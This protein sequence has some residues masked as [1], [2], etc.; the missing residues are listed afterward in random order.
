[1]PRKIRELRAQ[2]RASGFYL[3]RMH[4]SHSIWKHARLP[5]ISANISGNDG[6]D[7]KFYQEAEVRAALRALRDLD[8]EQPS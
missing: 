1:M 5:G 2:L 8:E 4:G 3:D 7:A 6:D